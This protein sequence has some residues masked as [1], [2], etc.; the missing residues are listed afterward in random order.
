M[1]ATMSKVNTNISML[2]SELIE[3]I[4][5]DKSTKTE[6]EQVIT[7]KLY[8]K[9]M[10]DREGKPKNKIFPD[11]YYY[12]NYNNRFNP[13]VYLAYIV[14]DKCKSPRKIPDSMAAL[15]LTASN[16]SFKGAFIQEWAYF[17]NGSSEN[18]FYMEGNEIITKYFEC[19]HPLRSQVYYF[20]SRTSKGI[21]VFRDL[22]KSPRSVVIHP[23]EASATENP[24]EAS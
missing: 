22:D 7:S 18:E 2:G 11:V 4:N 14:R 8:H 10:V 12:V 24:A 3:W 20:V 13:D 16:D 15:D 6:Q 19:D 1:G 23:T 5:S 21:K 17:Q 9:Y